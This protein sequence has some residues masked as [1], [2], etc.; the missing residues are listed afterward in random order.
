MN[1]QSVFKTAMPYSY[2]MID[3]IYIYIYIYI[4]NKNETKDYPTPCF[5]QLHK[6]SYNH[7]GINLTQTKQ[8]F[9]NGWSE[10]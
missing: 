8:F 4:Y 10:R 7:Q 2:I 5:M 3:V 6:C 1:V 9:H